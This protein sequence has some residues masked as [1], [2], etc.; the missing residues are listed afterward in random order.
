MSA[1]RNGHYLATIFG[2]PF[3]ARLLAGGPGELL[4]VLSVAE[5]D[6]PPADTVER[7]YEEAYR[8]LRRS[9]RCEYVY[10]NAIAAKLLL[11]RHSPQ[12]TTL[13]Q[14]VSVQASQADLVMI[15]GYATVYEIKTELDS[16]RRLPGQLQS[17]RR[18]FE[19]VVVVAPLEQ[20]HDLVTEL[21]DGVGVVALTPRYTLA[22]IQEPTT[23]EDLLDPAAMFDLLRRAE[24]QEIVREV[25]GA[26]PDV[27]NTR[28]YSECRGRFL[29]LP[30]RTAYRMFVKA[31]RE[32]QP[33][34][35][36]PKQLRSLPHSLALHGLAGTFTEGDLGA[37]QQPI[38]VS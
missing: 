16:L 8:L 36:D 11:G 29:E 38:P 15:N 13:L 14:E 24:F 6:L 2:R 5:I 37:L 3:L 10:K 27:P 22:T 30:K 34:K 1:L 35:L 32:R 4:H 18:V 9:Y 12:T 25:F 23:C 20:A 21:P 26:V 33:W 19:H 17:Y 7:V 28:M 31:L